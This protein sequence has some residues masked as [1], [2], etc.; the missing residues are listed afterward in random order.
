MSNSVFPSFPGVSMSVSKTQR[1]NT[2]INTSV[3][4]KRVSIARFVSPIWDFVLQYDF[5]SRRQRYGAI[6][7]VPV[8]SALSDPANL[9]ANDFAA[10]NGFIGGRKG[11]FDTWLFEDPTD[12]AIAQGQIG[13]GDG[14]TTA[15]QITRPLGEYAE[16]IQNI[17]GTPILPVTWTPN[18]AFGSGQLIVPSTL[19]I[20]RQQDP[21]IVGWQSSGWPAYYQCTTAGNSGAVEPNWRQIAPMTGLTIADGGATWTCKGAPF[22]AYLNGV[23]QNPSTYSVSA[24]GILTFTSPPGIGA[25]IA[26]TTSF[27]FRCAFKQDANDFAQFTQNFYKLGKLEFES[28]KL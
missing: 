16:P 11:R 5:V 20:L 22:V 10:F 19:A 27:Y 26:V 7:K 4:G 13:V 14:V 28:I 12:E 9:I 17:N 21:V 18:T 24:L 1:W 15:F 23:A 6:G 25:I 8:F 2:A 3:A